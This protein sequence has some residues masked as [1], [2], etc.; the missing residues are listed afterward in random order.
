M[1]PLSKLW[2][3]TMC[4]GCMCMRSLLSLEVLCWELAELRGSRLH[5]LNFVTAILRQ[6]SAI[7]ILLVMRRT[8]VVPLRGDWN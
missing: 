6:D 5:V 4:L 7:R 3:G 1:W 8:N 2:L